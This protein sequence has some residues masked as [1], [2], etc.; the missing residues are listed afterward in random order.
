MDSI[1]SR[2]SPQLEYHRRSKSILKKSD[3]SGIRGNDPE[4]ERLISD[5]TSGMDI[6]SGGECSPIKQLSS[7]PMLRHRSVNQQLLSRKSSYYQ[8]DS[9][10]TRTY[11]TPLISLDDTVKRQEPK[12]CNEMIVDNNRLKQSSC[13]V[14][15]VPLY[16]CPPPPPMDERSPTEETRL[17]YHSSI[18][19]PTAKPTR[20]SISKSMTPSS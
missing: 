4:S 12:I 17:L 2:S 16:I 9:D 5:S 1:D 18:A 6:S 19:M 8:N 10:N 20:N 15:E 7:P 3:G 14:G 13:S 11:K